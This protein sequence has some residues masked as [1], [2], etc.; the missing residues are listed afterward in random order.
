MSKNFI[1]KSVIVIILFSIAIYEENRVISFI[2]FTL[3]W[4]IILYPLFIKNTTNTNEENISTNSDEKVYKLAKEIH[5]NFHITCDILEKIKKFKSKEELILELERKGITI[6][7]D[8]VNLREIK[9]NFGNFWIHSVIENEGSS[10][11]EYGKYDFSVIGLRDYNNLNLNFDY[12]QK[13]RRVSCVD[14]DKVMNLKNNK[15]P[16]TGKYSLELYN[17]ILE[18]GGFNK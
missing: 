15:L 6:D 18:L 13:K 14:L 4:L 10:L 7:K 3:P 8:N 17:L 16:P 1:I 11:T 9:L 2:F 5:K 12:K